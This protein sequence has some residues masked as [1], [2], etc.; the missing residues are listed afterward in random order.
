MLAK[1]IRKM[2]SKMK[3]VRKRLHSLHLKK[4]YMV[5]AILFFLL[6]SWVFS[7]CWR[8]DWVREKTTIWFDPAGLLVVNFFLTKK[9]LARLVKYINPYLLKKSFTACSLWHSHRTIF[10]T[11]LRHFQYC[12]SL[13]FNILIFVSRQISTHISSSLSSILHF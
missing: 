12:K 8:G 3:K 10:S 13:W 1:Q 6:K 4:L 5:A 7:L 11:I 9:N 2:N